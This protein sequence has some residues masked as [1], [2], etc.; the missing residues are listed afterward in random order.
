MITAAEEEYILK[1]ALVPEHSPDLMTCVSGAEP[2]LI[3][4]HLCLCQKD[5]VIFVGYPLAGEFDRQALEELIRRVR[6]KFKPRYLSLIAPELPPGLERSCRERES[7]HY[8]TLAL[9]GF[10]LGSALRRA[11]KKAGNGLTL[12]RATEM[13]AEHG[14]LSREFIN[15]VGPPERIRRL[16]L[17]M[18]DYVGRARKSLVINARTEDGKLAAF[19]V[20]DPAPADFATYVIGCHSRENYVPGASDLV[21]YD[22]VRISREYGKSYIHL[23]LGVSAGIRRFKEKWGGRCGRSYEMCEMALRKPSILE[24]IQNYF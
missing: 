3:E 15:R 23:G 4:D 11:V 1:R 22:M 5:W 7:D 14:G 8:Y 10:K 9:E 6:K 17:K 20:V 19:Y 24:A 2:F 21:F 16:L 13:R 12:E 18:P